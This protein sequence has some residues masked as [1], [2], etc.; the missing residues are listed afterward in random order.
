MALSDEQIRRYTHNL[1]F[2]RM[3]ILCNHG[4]YG[5]LLMHLTYSLDETVRNAATDGKRILF[6][7]DFL[8]RLTDRELDYVMMHQVAHIALQH[9]MRGTQLEPELFH[10]ACDI[11]VNSHLLQEAG[12]D[13]DSISLQPDGP[14]IHTVPDGSE[15]YL[16]TT[17]QVYEML[18]KQAS[19][20]SNGSK[21]SQSALSS[22]NSN[23]NFLPGSNSGNIPKSPTPDS[24]VNRW[25]DHTLWTLSQEDDTLH[26]VWTHRVRE[27]AQSIEKRANGIGHSPLLVQRLLQELRS[28][29]TDWRV[30]LNDFIQEEITDYSFT[31]PDRRFDDSPFFLP[32][33]NDKSTV[34]KN[35]LFMIDTSGSM[36]DEMITAAYSEV[37]GALVQFGGKLE[38]WLGFFDAEIVPPQPFSDES[39]LKIIR[40]AGGGGTSFEIIFQYVADHMAQDPPA[41]II[42]LTD[43]YAPFPPQALAQ[44]IPVLWLLNNESVQPPWGKVARIKL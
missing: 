3:R 8:N 30:I 13:L 33:F 37:L 44:N 28:A 1:L 17:E 15:G 6:H 43:G 7:P 12:G 39:E 25:D 23:K 2:S 41:S 14:G 35:I 24:S 20:G 26:F 22:F 11:V 40:P 9:C 36:S 18:Q 5:L 4:F 27:A 29:Q 31:P 10:T 42:V 34:V 38:G 16:Y 32:D 19:S 21:T